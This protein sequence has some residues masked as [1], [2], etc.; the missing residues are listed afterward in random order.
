MNEPREWLIPKIGLVTQLIE[1]VTGADYY[2]E[3]TTHN[4]QF[5]GRVPMCEEEFE[6]ELS[7]LG[8][9]R[10]PL[11]SWKSL[12]SWRKVGFDDSPEMQLHVVLYDGEPMD[13]AAVDVTYVYA[14]WEIAW[15]V[16]PIAHY[17]GK[18]V[19]GPEGVRR[20]KKLLDEH[21]IGYE[22]IRP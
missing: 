6:K 9:T 7:G 5:V 3:S 20:M 15:D 22:P 10:N 13:N 17:C 1:D 2:V 4:N 16:H 8:F 19:N 18:R 14:H 21:G 12:E 11:S